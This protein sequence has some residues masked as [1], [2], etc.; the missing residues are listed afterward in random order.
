MESF[1]KE[2]GM[3]NSAR[4]MNFFQSQQQARRKT[5]LLVLYL[6]GSYIFII[7][8]FN[9]AASLAYWLFL[10][11]EA[12]EESR[13]VFHLIDPDLFPWVSGV[14]LFLVVAS[15]LYNLFR[16]WRVGGMAVVTMLKG[17]KI[18]GNTTDVDE[19]KVLNV[20]AE[21]SLASGTPV[22]EVY[23][24]PEEES[25]NAFAAGLSPEQALLVV[26]RGCLTNLDR[27]ELQGVIAHEFSHILNGDMRLNLR[28]MA[29]VNGLMVI[30]L[31]GLWIM[32]ESDSLSSMAAGGVVAGIGSIGVFCASVIKSAVSR[33]REFLADA[34]AVQFTRNP[35]GIAGA[36]EKILD[37]GSRI[38]NFRAG[39]VSHLFFASGVRQG[40]LRLLAT[41]PPL[42]ERIARID[43]TGVGPREEGRGEET[44][45]PV[46][47]GEMPVASLSAVGPA[48]GRVRVSPGKLVGS[49][50]APQAA[51]IRYAARLK[52]GIPAGL[53]GAVAS[54]A[55]ATALI[56]ALL[57]GK[58]EAISAQQF[59]LLEGMLP[60]EAI[61]TIRALVAEKTAMR[62][63][64]RLPLVD[65]ALPALKSLSPGEYRQFRAAMVALAEADGEISLFEFML[66]SIIKRRLDPVLG[67]T[68]GGAPRRQAKGA[69]AGQTRVLL[70]RLAREGAA[71]DEAAERTYQ[72]GMAIY[73]PVTSPILAREECGLDRLQEA[74]TG[75]GAASLAVQARLIQ[76]CLY[77]I[78]VDMLIT[79]EEAELMR[80][81]ADTLG[82]PIPPILPGLLRE[83]D[84]DEL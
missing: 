31:L 6:L 55:G 40:F 53:A 82:I 80:A 37:T 52:E 38:N 20:V 13:P 34:S 18:N 41:H 24:I 59:A 54:P 73:G 67:E 26:T 81:V 69:V 47:P 32:S 56:H 79:A 42:R 14:V 76:A 60:P 11:R 62:P 22:P 1:A 75:L 15:T 4:T 30:T 48:A 66:T 84:W 63:E 29:T 49:I 77:A 57:I 10:W 74:L 35:R 45:A 46:L 25:I 28:L 2:A 9:L 7:G 68:P 58:E 33:Q 3:G 21:M 51:H 71:D 23:I 61:E 12:A 16:L 64:Q 8:F 43:P 50:G 65:L 83:D 5:S 70:S 39:E 36:L 44:A 78:S 72:A 19:R 17:R 27:D